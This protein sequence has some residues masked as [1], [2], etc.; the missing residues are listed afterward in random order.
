MNTASLQI[1]TRVAVFTFYDE[2][3]K[4]WAPLQNIIECKKKI[5]DEKK[6]YD[7]NVEGMQFLNV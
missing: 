7:I 3:V 4:P 1:W 5:T 2:T 6:I